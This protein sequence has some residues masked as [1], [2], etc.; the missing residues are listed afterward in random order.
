MVGS[1]PETRDHG[2]RYSGGR[3]PLPRREPVLTREAGLLDRSPTRGL[4][5]RELIEMAR[6]ARTRATPSL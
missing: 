2:V 4:T 6:A 3:L 1:Q 5:A